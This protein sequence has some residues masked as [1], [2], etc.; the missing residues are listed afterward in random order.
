MISH[1]ES[2]FISEENRELFEAIFKMIPLSE[3]K[4]LLGQREDVV[5]FNI[6]DEKDLAL[7]ESESRE[8]FPYETHE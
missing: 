1:D 8:V 2:W 7:M 3:I 6:L 4:R 5:G